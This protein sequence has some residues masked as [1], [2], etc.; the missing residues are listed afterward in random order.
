MF[1]RLKITDY[2]FRL[3]ALVIA[4]NVIGNLAVGSANPDY[5][6]KELL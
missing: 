4:I 1:K 3:I 2:D 6:K 5:V